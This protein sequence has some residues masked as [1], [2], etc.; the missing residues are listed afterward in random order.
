MRD[1][2]RNKYYRNGVLGCTDAESAAKGREILRKYNAKERHGIIKDFYEKMMLPAFYRVF[3]Y[4]TIVFKAKDMNTVLEILREF[5]KETNG[6]F[7]AKQEFV[8][9]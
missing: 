8:E 6:T 3:L 1:W 9:I 7:C 2:F 4:D 5:C